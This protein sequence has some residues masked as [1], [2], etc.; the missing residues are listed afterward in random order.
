[1]LKKF[2]LEQIEKKEE[3][4]EAFMR[5]QA[6]GESMTDAQHHLN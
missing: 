3:I 4:L 6:T 2:L 1:M 5:S